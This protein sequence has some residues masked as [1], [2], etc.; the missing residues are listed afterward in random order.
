MNFTSRDKLFN[1]LFD[2]LNDIFNHNTLSHYDKRLDYG[3]YESIRSFSYYFVREYI[4]NTYGFGPN[5][6]ITNKLCREWLRKNYGV[7]NMAMVG[8]I[9]EMINMPDD[10]NPILPGTKGMVVGYNSVGGPFNEDHMSVNWENGRNL[11]L[12]VGVDEFK[13]VKKI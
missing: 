12:I 2:D 5:D 11:S 4:V 1:Q 9:I 8:D 13:V 3:R 10:P 6:P 7:G